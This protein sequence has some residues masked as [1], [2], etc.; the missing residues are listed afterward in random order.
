M[1]AAG[2]DRPDASAVGSSRPAGQGTLAVKN[3]IHPV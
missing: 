1:D 2:V 3:E